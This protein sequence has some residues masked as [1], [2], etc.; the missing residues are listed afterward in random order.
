MFKSL[1]LSRKW[2]FNN[3]KQLK[4]ENKKLMEIL[5]L[6]NLTTS[7][8]IDS[9]KKKEVVLSEYENTILVLEMKLRRNRD[10]KTGRFIKAD[11]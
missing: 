9:L 11:D 8:L 7:Q 1:F 4:E 3:I 5:S 2:L 6:K 10:P